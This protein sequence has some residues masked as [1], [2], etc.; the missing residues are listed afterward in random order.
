MW[1]SPVTE[2]VELWRILPYGEGP[3]E[4]GAV[5]TLRNS[6]QQHT[7]VR[8]HCYSGIQAFQEFTLY[9]PNFEKGPVQHRQ[10]RPR[11]L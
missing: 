9:V 6:G 7:Q 5:A 10:K 8:Q 1:I 11:A 3:E 2:T 4:P